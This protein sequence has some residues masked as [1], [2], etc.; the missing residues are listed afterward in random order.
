MW[1]RYDRNNNGQVAGWKKR[2]RF[3]LIIP[4]NY[5]VCA[6]VWAL[7]KWTHITHTNYFYAHFCVFV[8]FLSCSNRTFF[9]CVLYR[10]IN[11][12]LNIYSQRY[13]RTG[14][15]W[16]FFSYVVLFTKRQHK[17]PNKNMCSYMNGNVCSRRKGK[18]EWAL[19]FVFSY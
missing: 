7:S 13:E 1:Q 4:A 5:F 3:F 10:N 16:W 14:W 19:W 17:S 11:F 18:R 9:C 12:D 2:W 6:W 15:Y 8:F